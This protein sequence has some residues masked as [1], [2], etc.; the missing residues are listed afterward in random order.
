M[1]IPRL[2]EQGRSES[3][4]FKFSLDEPEGF[5]REA[6]K[7]ALIFDGQGSFAWELGF[8]QAVLLF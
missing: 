1:K 2:T 5:F 4:T 7:Q 3:L 6:F 8:Q